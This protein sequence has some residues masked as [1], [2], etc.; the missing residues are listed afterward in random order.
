MKLKFLGLI[1]FIAIGLFVTKGLVF[2]SGYIVSIWLENLKVIKNPSDIKA[3]YNRATLYN[4]C[5]DIEAATRDLVSITNI[6]LSSIDINSEL[7]DL[8]FV[9]GAYFKLGNIFLSNNKKYDAIANYKKY[10][11]FIGKEQ[12]RDKL[13]ELSFIDIKNHEIEV[14]KEL[15]QYKILTFNDK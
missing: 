5:G 8:N 2:N 7:S 3:L 6:N 11:H 9:K 4:E 13:F 1:I 12:D 14:Y 10:I 15:L